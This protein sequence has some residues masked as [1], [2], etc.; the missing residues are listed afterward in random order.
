MDSFNDFGDP[1]M[2]ELANQYSEKPVDHYHSDV[3]MF[4]NFSEFE[5]IQQ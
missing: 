4:N 5:Q 2:M 3:P 1:F